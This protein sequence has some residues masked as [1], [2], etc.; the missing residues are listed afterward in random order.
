M[1]SSFYTK[2]FA[3]I[4]SQ[5]IVE[6]LWRKIQLENSIEDCMIF[7]CRIPVVYKNAWKYINI[8]KNINAEW[9]YF[10]RALALEFKF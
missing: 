2:I 8:S 9:W 1:F 7:Y 4:S 5:Y 6:K 10:P 3:T